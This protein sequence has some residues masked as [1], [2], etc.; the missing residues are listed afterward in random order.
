M[1]VR[2]ASASAGALTLS[3]AIAWGS[4]SHKV[5]VK[6]APATVQTISGTMTG[7]G[8]LTKDGI[9][10]L[11]ITG[12]NT[13]T[14]D[15]RA[16]GAVTVNEGTLRI[17]ADTALGIV[18]TSATAGNITLN[19]GALSASA[20]MT[21]NTNRGIALGSA[22]GSGTGII[23][24]VTSGQTLTYG[25]VIANSGSGADNLLKTGAGTLLLNGVNSYTGNTTIG[26]GTLTLGA[27]ASIDS[28]ARI[29]V[30][31]GANFNVAAVTGGYQLKSGQTLEGGGTVTGAFTALA[32][33]VIVP[34]TGV[35][36]IAEKLTFSSGLTLA[37]ASTLQLQITTATF[38]S[39]DNFGG[40]DYG[41]SGYNSY[42]TSH[43]T[44]Q[45]EHDLL[46]VT[47]ALTQANGAKIQVLGSNFT[48]AH[49]QIFNLL[50]W[51]TAFSTSNNLGD[52]TRYGNADGGL[53]LDLPDISGSGFFWDTSHFA[54][55][56]VISVV[57]IPEPSRGMLLVG[58]FTV[59]AFRRRR[60]KA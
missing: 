47:G 25:G 37:S 60:S 24:V 1:G 13:T 38:T 27:A 51:T 30:G 35:N 53:D 56:G 52:T 8:S 42:I 59:L 36:H 41:T 20:T 34:G 11:A 9:G 23:D 4:N 6:S 10:T 14:L 43:A 57:S 49:G 31:T 44:G 21:L 46:N 39:T 17:G 29:T 55:L 16:A 7:S 40:N 33:S 22:T 2:G 3:G 48:P 45:G 26:T 32:G 58:A 19:G 50:D 28:S 18:P 12:T 15:W 5:T 54:T